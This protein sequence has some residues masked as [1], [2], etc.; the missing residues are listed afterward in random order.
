MFNFLKLSPLYSG[1]YHNVN[2]NLEI[3]RDINNQRDFA[4]MQAISKSQFK[5]K[6]NFLQYLVYLKIKVKMKVAS[7]ISFSKI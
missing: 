3:K 1:Q 7:D 4:F 2:S 5:I 6:C